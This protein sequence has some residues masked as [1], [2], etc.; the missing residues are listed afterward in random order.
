MR[1][2]RK[3]ARPLNHDLIMDVLA[4]LGVILFVVVACWVLSQT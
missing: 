2:R 1:D 4:G 3:P